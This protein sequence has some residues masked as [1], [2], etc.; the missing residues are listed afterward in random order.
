MDRE[1]ASTVRSYDDTP[2][3][4]GY[5][6]DQVEVEKF[7]RTNFGDKCFDD[8]EERTARVLEE[9]IELYDAEHKKR[10]AARAAAHKLV[11]HVFDQRKGSVNQELGGLTITALAYCA[12]KGVRM[13]KAAETEIRRVLSLSKEHFRK[14]QQAKASAGV[15]L[16]P[17]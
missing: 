16:P 9:A 1:P 2:N 13:D 7:V 15:A 5:G 3:W 6:S 10:D 8:L 11:D 14:N 17:D 12:A 4:L